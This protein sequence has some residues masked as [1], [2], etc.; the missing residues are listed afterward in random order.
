MGN[1]SFFLE[2]QG[3]Q[4]GLFLAA[5]LCWSTS[6][7]MGNKDTAMIRR[8]TSLKLLLMKGK[9]P[10]AYPSKEIPPTH[11]SPPRC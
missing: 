1:G 8:E 2:I 11:N 6:I 3:F 5:L 10:K 9:L 4:G 7:R